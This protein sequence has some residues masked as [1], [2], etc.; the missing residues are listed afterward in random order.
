MATSTLAFTWVWLLL[1]G[2]VGALPVG[3]AP[4]PLDPALSAIA[5]PKCLWY[6]SVS[7]QGPADPASTN[8]TEQLIAEPQVQR[9]V[10]EIETQIMKAVRRGAGPRREQRILAAQ[11]PKVIRTLLTRP[12]VAYVEEVTP[13]EGDRPEFHVEAAAVLNA[14]EQSKELK[15]AIEELLTLV[16]EEAPDLETETVADVEWRRIPTPPNKPAVRFG[17]KDDY[18]II[19]VGDRTPQN[20]VS[21]MEGDAPQWLA[22][23][24]TEHPIPRETSLGYLNIAGILELMRPFVQDEEPDAWRVVETLGLTKIL[25]LHGVSGYDDVACQSIAHIVT[26]D[27][28]RPGLLGLLPHEPLEAGDLGLIPKDA[29]FAVAYRL[30]L[31]E[32]WDHALDMAEEI[33]PNAREEFEEELWKGERELGINVRDDIVDSLGSAAFAY[34]PSGDLLTS[35]LNAVAGVRVDDAD[36]LRDVIEKFVRIAQH[37]F[38]R[39]NRDAPVIVET[40]FGDQTIYSLQFTRE[41]VPVSPSWCVGDDWAVVGLLP[42]AVRSA[43][44]RKAEDSLA[45]APGMAEALADGAAALSY[46]DTPQL[47]KTAYPWVQIGV[48]M[49][50]AQLRRANI[51]I[52][53][54][55]LPSVDV[56]VKH[57]RPAVATFHHADDGFH[58][59]SRHSLPGGG[60][61]AAAAPVA[62]GLLL[63]AIGAARTAAQQ[64]YDMNSAKQLMLGM[65]NY[66]SA[67][68]QLPSN[69]YSDDGKPLLS[70]RVQILPY[71]EQQGLYQQF[72]MDEP[73]DSEHNRKL[74]ENMPD[75]FRSPHDPPGSTKTRFLAVAGPETLFPGNERVSLAKI[76]DGTSNTLALVQVAPEKAVEWTKPDDWEMDADDPL[77]GLDGRRGSFL[78]AMCDGSVRRISLGVDPEVVKALVT[79]AGD[80]VVDRE[81]LNRPQPPRPLV[82]AR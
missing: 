28:E 36:Q 9:F 16:P 49:A 33:E 79:R 50:S 20:I 10:K 77:A 27:G 54:T 5:P 34:L 63:P 76:T 43:L 66:E 47:V 41:P 30:D 13:I 35:W 17:W 64:T 72:R 4:L 32:V 57:L 71:V 19:A 31:G 53:P 6:M 21:R 69:V 15:S 1:A 68:K 2:G 65:L 60:N 67:R 80:E 39:G 70:W 73:W 51:E 40:P 29:M 81:N 8:Q 58:L 75:V 38:E 22:D 12:M 61:V 23:M 55:A 44:E 3:G 59:M 37:E 14:G 62:V 46:Q 11:L 42:Q 82:P 52:D 45:E 56:I 78:A 24:R 25:A 18:F 48:Q 7:G 74:L 26:E